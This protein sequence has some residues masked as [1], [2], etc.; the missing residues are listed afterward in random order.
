[1]AA[2]LFLPI[3]SNGGG[4]DPR[5]MTGILDAFSGRDFAFLN[6]SDPH[7]ANVLSMAT[8]T[9]LKTDC[10]EMV[11]VDADVE[12]TRADLDRLLSHDLPIVFGWYHKKVFP[13]EACVVGLESEGGGVLRANSGLKEFAAAGRGFVRIHRSVFEHMLEAEEIKTFTNMS[14]AG[15][16]VREIWQSGVH[17][18]SFQ[19]EDFNFCRRIR[20]LG[21]KVLVDTHAHV[22]HWG[23]FAYGT[24]PDLGTIA[25]VPIEEEQPEPVPA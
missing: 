19:H 21:Y 10:E 2:K 15:D 18:G 23:A 16:P 13:P 24:I 22:K 14:P 25:P 7:P 20:A 1:M 12:I 17:E 5:Y 11:I 3:C 6:V 9:F 4:V 8:H